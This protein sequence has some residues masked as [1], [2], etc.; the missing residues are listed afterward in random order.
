M[1]EHYSLILLF[2]GVAFVIG[3]FYPILPRK[4]SI[5]LPMIQ[6][7]IGAVV[8]YFLSDLPKVHPLNYGIAIEKVTEIVVLISLVGCGIKLDT[9]LSL[10]AWQPTMRLLLIVMPVGVAALAFMGHYIFGLS[11]A[12][13]ILLGAVLAPTD[14]VLAASIQVGPPNSEDDEDVTRFSLTSEAGLN[15]GL[16]FPFVYLALAMA[17]AAS[18]HQHFGWQDWLHWLGYDVVWRIAAAL[19]VGVAVGKLLAKWLFGKTA[20]D[21]VEQSYMVVALMLLA[22]SLTEMVHGYGFIAVFIAALTFRR[23]EHEH[24]YHEGL[25]DFAE[26]MEGLLMSLVMV[27][28]GLLV[29]QAVASDV[30]PSWQVYVV[31]LAFLFLVRPIVGYFGLSRLG[32]SKNERW[33]TAGLGIRGIGTLYYVSYAANKG[34]FSQDEAVKIWVICVV[35][36]AMSVFLHG[37]TANRLLALTKR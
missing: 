15:D 34:V 1:I 25:H 29:G 24:Q 23:S 7:T 28:L 13:A 14:P 21:R 26:Q 5:S 17:T 30:A 33:V 10:K 20:P 16:A 6:L 18:L 37:L 31:C 32:M 27:F 35:M 11:V 2:L 8:G 9:P 4:L 22:Y 36:I 12:A 19:G 3:A